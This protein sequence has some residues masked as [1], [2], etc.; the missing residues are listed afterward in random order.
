MSDTLTP[1]VFNTHTYC[2]VYADSALDRAKALDIQVN[3]P[4]ADADAATKAAS[5]RVVKNAQETVDA[6]AEVAVKFGIA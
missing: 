3:A 5:A 1:G 2:K 6:L 4:E